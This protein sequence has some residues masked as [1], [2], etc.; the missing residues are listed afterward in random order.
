MDQADVEFIRAMIAHHQAA[1]E[2]A[3]EYLADTSPRTRQARVADWARQ[4]ATGQTA[5]IKMVRGWLRAA[6]ETAGAS[7]SSDMSM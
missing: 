1:I 7:K 2:M 6:G 3:N 4:I 5:E